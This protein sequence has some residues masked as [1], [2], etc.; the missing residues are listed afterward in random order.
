MKRFL[1]AA[2]PLLL[3]AQPATA[4]DHSAHQPAPDPHAHHRPAPTAQDPHAG[5]RMDAPAQDPHAG[6]RMDAP[7]QDPHA[8]HDMPAD[9]HAGHD[10]PAPAASDPHAGHDMGRTVADPHAGHA[11]GPPDTVTSA[12]TPGRPPQTPPPAAAFSGPTHAADLIFGADRMA[13]AREQMR[14]ENGDVR[15]TAVIIDRLEAGFGDG[16]E[17]FL[18]DVQGWTGGDIQRFWWK[19]EADGE[20]GERPHEIEVQ[21]LYSHAV[22]PFC[23][24]TF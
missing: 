2:A 4:Q 21:A 23:E 7:A 20:F 10:M 5:H 1:I 3:A 14:R 6:H 18:W 8:G 16:E 22:T 19:T 12:D 11:M 15:T 24:V 17:T 9:P 13:A